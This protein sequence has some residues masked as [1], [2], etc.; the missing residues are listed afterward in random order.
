MSIENQLSDSLVSV[1]QTSPEYARLPPATRAVLNDIIRTSSVPFLQQLYNNVTNESNKQ[2]DL[3][4]SNLIGINNPV[5]IVSSNLTNQDL[6]E[7]LTPSIDTKFTDDFSSLLYNTVFNNFKNKIPPGVLQG[8]DLL[9]LSGILESASK[10]GVEKAINTSLDVFTRDLFSNSQGIPPIV[11]NIESL[12]GSDPVAGLQRVNQAYDA[13]LSN[14]AINEAKA[15]DI[16]KAENQEKLITQ[17]VGFIDPAAA[18]PTK[19]YIGRS[20][21]N[22][23]ATGDVNGTIVQQKEMQRVKGIQLPNNERWEQPQVTYNAEYPYNKVLQTESG[24][25]IEMDDTPGSE[26]LQV[27]HRSGTF[28]EIDPNGTIIKRTKGT[29]YEIID[30]NGYIAV[31]GDAHLSVSGATKIFVGGNADIEVEGDT[32]VKSLNDITVQAAGKMNLSATEEI[33]IASANVNIEAYHTINFKSKEKLNAYVEKDLN[34]KSDTN[35]YVETPFYYNKSTSYYNQVATDLN[36]KIGGSRFSEVDTETHF[37]S[38]GSF[39]VD[40]SRVDLNSGTAEGSQDSKPAEKAGPSYIGVIG[41]RRDIKVRPIPNATTASFLDVEGYKAEDAEFPEEANKQ[42][43]VLTETGI[44]SNNNFEESAIVIESDTPRSP[45]TA[46]I[47]PSDSLLSQ[48]YLPDNYQLSKHFT[49]AMLSSKAVVTKNPVV[50]QVGLSYGELIYNLQGM[51]L[52]ICEPVLALYPNMM[53]TS[54]FRVAKNSS[55]TSDHPRGRAVDIQFK[56]VPKAEYFE[57]AKRLASQLNYDKLLLEYKTYGTGLPWIHI[58]FDVTKQRKIV[59][60]YLN[61]KKYGDGLVSL[62]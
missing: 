16:K 7:T 51:A 26:R 2:L 32:N 50:A 52:N 14:Q 34:I 11:S 22:K 47:M 29:S 15:F 40:G 43:Q 57:I 1:F 33:N 17:T 53:V 19:E 27:Y 6:T 10:T 21:A 49:L 8:I 31:S 44:A 36:E 62:A 24:H 18:F 35:L 30:R 55:S 28:I 9:N 13:S 54:A 59:L 39:N 41:E 61:D 3:I 42:K 48:T 45:S 60:T 38:A 5:D 56:N 23:L 25:I 58:S 12:F 4:P 37:K 46:I 20:E